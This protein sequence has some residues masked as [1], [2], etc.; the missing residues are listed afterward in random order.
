MMRSGRHSQSEKMLVE[1]IFPSTAEGSVWV[2]RAIKLKK[3]DTVRINITGD[4]LTDIS[5]W[6]AFE[7]R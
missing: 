1:G 5:Y 4:F 3:G 2:S 6:G 7:L